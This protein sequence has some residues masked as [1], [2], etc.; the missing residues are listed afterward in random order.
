V[1]SPLKLKEKKR[2]N[3]DNPLLSQKGSIKSEDKLSFL[4]DLNSTSAEKDEIQ[5]SRSYKSQ[6][7]SENKLKDHSVIHFKDLSQHKRDILKQLRGR[8]SFSPVGSKRGKK[9][10][11]KVRSKSK[12]RKGKKGKC[13]KF[14]FHSRAVSPKRCTKDTSKVITFGKQEFS[15][16]MSH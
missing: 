12:F 14:T 8:I 1:C 10:K 15:R 9:S 5:N 11:T 16:V 2:F 6:I 7:I 3:S 13:G 4:I